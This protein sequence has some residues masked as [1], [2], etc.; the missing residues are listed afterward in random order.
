MQNYKTIFQARGRSYH[1]AMRSYPGA[2]VQEFTAAV[3]LLNQK[4]G[5]RILD[6]PAGGGYLE[7]Y[8][9]E[10]VTYIAYDFAGEFEDGH[11]QVAKCEEAKIDLPD[12]SSDEAL[13]LAAMHHIV[14]RSAFYAELARILKPGGKLVI[15]DVISGSLEDAFLNGFVDRWNS[16]GH[17]GVFLEPAHDIEQIGNQGFKV[18]F[19]TKSYSWAFINETEA[20]DFFRKLFFLN[21]EPSTNLV[22]EELRRLGVNEGSGKYDVNWS[23]GFYVAEKL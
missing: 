17:K 3:A 7:S 16:M 8:L 18:T 15:G 9:N 14:E 1:E 10:D 2:R 13:S 5:S 22:S 21:K 12:A 19:E 11:S 6:L 20:I 4:P 23:L